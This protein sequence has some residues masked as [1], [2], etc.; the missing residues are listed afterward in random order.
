MK[1]FGRPSNRVL[2]VFGATGDLAARKLFPGFFHLFREGL[3]PEQFRII[4]SGRDSPGSDDAFRQRIHAALE[5]H[6]R[7]ELDEQW[8]EFAARLSFVVSTA[9]D[10]DDLA[11]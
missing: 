9:E 6:G 10:G 5:E 3:M 11:R 7:V 8:E 4:G 1:G 2:V